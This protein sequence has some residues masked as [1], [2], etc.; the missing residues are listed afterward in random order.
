MYKKTENT[1]DFEE[2]DQFEGP[3]PSKSATFALI[4][5][6]PYMLEV[7][8]SSLPRQ[9]DVFNKYSTKRKKPRSG[10]LWSRP[11]FQN[12]KQAHYGPIL[13]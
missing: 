7:S 2:L 11:L 5:V 3:K 12:I 10:S 1:S 6:D 4:T 13:P 9:N 8:G